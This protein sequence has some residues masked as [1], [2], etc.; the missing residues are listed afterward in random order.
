MIRRIKMRINEFKKKYLPVVMLSSLALTTIFST[1]VMAGTAKGK[2]FIALGDQIVEVQGAITS[3]EDQVTELIG[4]VDSID[5]RLTANEQAL[6]NLAAENDALNALIIGAY[7]SIDDINTEIQNLSFDVVEN[8]GLIAS[9]QSAIAAIETGQFDLSEN[10]QS[11]I[12]NNLELIT[13]IQGNIDG[14]N[15]Y[16]AMDQ[17]ITEGTC[18]EGLY[19]VGHTADSLACAPIDGGGSS[20]ISSYFRYQRSQTWGRNIQVY[21]SPGDIA[22]GGGFNAIQSEHSVRR[23]TPTGINGWTVELTGNFRDIQAYVMCLK[24]N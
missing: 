15:D 13:I 1:A 11:L 5:V 18:S 3:L 21:C 4:R 2:P 24:V 22:T 9:L 23:S 12:N 8:A 14:I 17:H 6:V 16:I 19:V 7:T 10:L 20:S